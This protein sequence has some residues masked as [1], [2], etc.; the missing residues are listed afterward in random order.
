MG[1]VVVEP[2]VSMHDPRPPPQVEKLPALQSELS[3]AGDAED[4]MVE[5]KR[6]GGVVL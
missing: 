6:C 3:R 4:D 5:G 2:D 1:D